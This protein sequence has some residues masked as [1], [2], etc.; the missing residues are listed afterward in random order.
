MTPTSPAA[1]P[2]GG[3]GAPFAALLVGA[4]AMGISPIFVRVADVGPFA[5]AFW[6]VALALPLL[7]AWL[8]LSEK[9]APADRGIGVADVLAGVAFT[10]DLF[11]WHLSI[12]TTSVANATFFATTAPIWVVAFGWLL[13][14]ERAAPRT[15]VGIALCV[16]GGSALVAQSF[17]LRP[18]GAIGDLYGLAT[19]V[20]FGLYFLAVKAARRV[21]S[22]ARVTFVAT[23]ITA[24]LLLAVALAL[25]PTILP[26][27]LGGVAA[28]FGM[29]WI[30]HAGGQGLLSIALGR[31]PAT[32]SS[33]VIF[34]E[35]IAAATFAFLLLGEPV[36]L[37][38]GFGGLAIL[39]GIYVARPT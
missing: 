3:F 35:A 21:H 31:L 10:C 16:L 9:E 37:A 1:K 39:A 20:F 13:L 12:V 32:F 28:L 19:G 17:H 30:S 22:A 4:L 8:K 15:L 25:E 2:P 5:S 11:F 7:W 14:G 33:L 6:R 34:L 38:Q 26:H 23:V 27:S 24:A 18:A 36:S 29:A